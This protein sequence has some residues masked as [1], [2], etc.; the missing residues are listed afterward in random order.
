MDHVRT[1]LQPISIHVREIEPLRKVEV[2]LNRAQLPLPIKHVLHAD[3]DLRS[4]EGAIP[5]VQRI[6]K[7]TAV[8]RG[9]E[10]GLCR[11]PLLLRAYPSL[12][13]STEVEVKILQTEITQKV[14]A[15]VEDGIDLL[16]H[17]ILTTEEMRVVLRE[18]ANSGQARQG[19]AALEPVDRSPLRESFRKISIRFRNRIIDLTVKRTVH[20]LEVVLLALNLDWSE[21][22]ILIERKMP[23]RF[24]EGRATDMR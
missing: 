13:A 6:R 3:I 7:P 23:A 5:F 18:P 20:R 10:G 4:I 2:E 11:V 16:R 8:K 22:P 1:F 9:L 19:A 21:H 17:L 24:P 12:W 15:E 14:Y